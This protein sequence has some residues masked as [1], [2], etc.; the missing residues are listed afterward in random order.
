MLHVRVFVND[1][2]SRLDLGRFGGL[3]YSFTERAQM[4]GACI[5]DEVLKALQGR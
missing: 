1:V 5:I 4:Q 3:V 2:S